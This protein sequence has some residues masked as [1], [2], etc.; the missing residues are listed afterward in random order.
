[1]VDAHKTSTQEISDLLALVDR[2]LADCQLSE[3]SPDWRL[4]I[5]YNAALQ[6]ATAALATAGYRAAR[7]LTTIGLF[8]P[9]PIQSALQL[10]L[11]LSLISSAKK[12]TSAVMSGPE[13]HPIRKRKRCS[14]WQKYSQ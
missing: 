13:Q 14:F 6:A 9:L 3:L 5:A 4:N 8:N 10:V 1:M 12:E 11:L 7:N 2:D